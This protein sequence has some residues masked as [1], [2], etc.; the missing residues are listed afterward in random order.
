VE[1]Y[2][3]FL[4]RGNKVTIGNRNAVGV[5]RMVRMVRMVGQGKFIMI[6]EKKVVFSYKPQTI[7]IPGVRFDRTTLRL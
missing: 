6:D 7:V 1:I 3:N 4:V 5:V 2:F